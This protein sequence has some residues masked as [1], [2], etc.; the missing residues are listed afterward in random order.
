MTMGRRAEV[1][2]RSAAVVTY[3]HDR[4]R[5]RRRR[6]RNVAD[7][8]LVAAAALVQ[9]GRRRYLGPRFSVVFESSAGVL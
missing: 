3:V 9:H 2:S 8:R 1:G 6:R 5:R 4:V 7:R